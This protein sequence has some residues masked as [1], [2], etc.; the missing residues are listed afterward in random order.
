[1][2]LKMPDPLRI[3]TPLSRCGFTT[4]EPSLRWKICRPHGRSVGRPYSSWLK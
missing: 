1:L 2:S 4:P 3:E